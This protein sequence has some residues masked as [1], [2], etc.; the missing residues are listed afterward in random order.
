MT[1]ILENAW[2]VLPLIV[3]F[4]LYKKLAYTDE[5]KTSVSKSIDPMVEADYNYITDAKDYAEQ[6][7]W[8]S[9]FDKL[10]QLVSDEYEGKVKVGHIQWIFESIEKD[11]LKPKNIPLFGNEPPKKKEV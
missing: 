9:K 6:K 7:G 3:I 11:A 5:V 10:F 2:V 4:I 1:Y 8:S